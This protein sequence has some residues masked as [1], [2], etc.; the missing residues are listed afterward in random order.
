MDS[1]IDGEGA[2]AQVGRH[3]FREKR[4]YRYQLHADTD[5]GDEAPQVEPKDIVLESHD[6]ARHRVPKQRV[7][8][9]GAATETVGDE[10]DQRRSDEESREHGRDKSRDAGS[11]KK[12]GR[13][14]R[15]DAGADQAW[16]DV[17]GEK[18]VVE[19]EETAERD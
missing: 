4:V 2:A 1:L 9:D 13:G 15:Q 12:A 6:D 17:A 3:H 5:S 11:G 18:D 19:L 16:R 10:T 8:E 14:G 7:S